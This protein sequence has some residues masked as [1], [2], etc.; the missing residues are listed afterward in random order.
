MDFNDLDLIVGR[1]LLDNHN[2][3]LIY[4]AGRASLNS[5]PDHLPNSD[6]YFTES[7]TETILDSCE[8]DFAQTDKL[9]LKNVIIE[10]E[11]DDIEEIIDNY[12]VRVS[13]KDTSTYAYAPRKFAFAERQKIREIVDDLLSRG[14]IK[15][16][17][18]PYCARIVPVRKKNGDL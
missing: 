2:L 15:T 17:S 8:I 11:N 16:S 7:V 5:F 14:I 6:V 13:L 3:T 1:D 18:S 9:A 4:H 10:V 12:N